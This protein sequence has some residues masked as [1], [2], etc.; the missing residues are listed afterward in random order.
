MAPGGSQRPLTPA[1]QSLSDLHEL[2]AWKA[3]GQLPAGG[4][5]E[6]AAS[7]VR[8]LIG[9]L[10]LELPE[11]LVDPPELLP[12]L[13]EVLPELPELLPE[14]PELLPELL[15]ELPEPLPELPPELLPRSGVGDDEPACPPHPLGAKANPHDKKKL[16]TANAVLAFMAPGS[17]ERCAVR[18]RSQLSGTI[19]GRVC[20]SVTEGLSSAAL[21]PQRMAPKEA[22]LA[23]R[24]SVHLVS[25]SSPHR[26]ARRDSASTSQLGHK[27]MAG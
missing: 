3:V 18:D 5:T 17:S 13:P 7:P 26:A 2:F 8:W 11:L 15:L 12:L 9:T 24:R 1:V 22:S 16:H 4:G 23:V 10:P 6:H 25:W 20:Q 27:S 14:L 19:S 21:H